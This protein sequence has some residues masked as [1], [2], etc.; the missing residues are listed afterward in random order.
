MARTY[1]FVIR[2][3]SIYDGSGAPPVTGDI[4]VAGDRIAAIG[5]VTGSTRRT[6][7]VQGLAVAPGFI[8]MLSWAN[9]PLLADGRSMS[10]IKQGVTLEVMGE[11]TSMG[12]LNERMKHEMINRQGDIK[13]DVA[14]TTLDE[15]LA[16]LVHRG[17]SCNVASFIGA[18]SVRIHELGYENRPPSAAELDRMRGLVAQ[19]MEGGAMGM[20]SALIYAPAS[21]SDTDELVA[22]AEV[23]AEYG[24]MYISHIRSEEAQVFE[25]LAEFFHIVRATGATGEIYHLKVS[26][27]ANWDKLAVVISRIEAAQARE[28]PVTADMYPYTASST[29]LDTAIPGWA[30]EGGQE[31]LEARL[32]DPAA[33][34]RIKEEIALFTSPEKIL[35]VSFKDDALKPLI[36]RTLAEVAAMRGRDYRDSLM[37]LIAEDHSRIGAVFFTMSEDNVRKAVGLPWVSFGSDGGSLAAE[38][39]FLKSGTHPRAYGTFARV[40]GKY[41]REE[42]VVTLEEAIRRM[43]S[44]PAQNL[45][46]ERRGRLAEDYHAD[47]VVFDPTAIRDTATFQQPHQYAVGVHHVFVNGVQVLKNGEHTGAMPGRVIRGPGSQD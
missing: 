2:N 44:F 35:V 36:G 30:H 40:L 4:A 38:G 6:L 31:A 9:A 32:H 34:A 41:V 18:T 39:V 21:Y 42:R 10:D 16:H 26:G 25:A 33:R 43:T 22:L 19:A 7:D 17:V 1:D 8:N 24:G 12:P 23:I 27:E 47:I 15:Y 45:K 29:G 5:R 37:D 28:L 14:W 46:L 11:G 13:F 20:S 3:G